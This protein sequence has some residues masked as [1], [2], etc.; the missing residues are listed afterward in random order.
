MK[1]Y[2]AIALCLVASGVQA[3]SGKDDWVTFK[4]SHNRSGKIEHQIERRTITKYPG[5]DIFRRKND[6]GG[7]V[8]CGDLAALVLGPDLQIHQRISILLVFLRN[9]AFAPRR[10]THR[11]EAT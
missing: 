10:V 1:I 6:G 11:V 9:L 2:G 8:R 3:Q 7:T 5:R 4:I